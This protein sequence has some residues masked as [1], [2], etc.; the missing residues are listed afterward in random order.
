M[1]IIKKI[2]YKVKMISERPI[3]YSKQ[4]KDIRNYMEYKGD[5]CFICDEQFD[6]DDN[7]YVLFMENMPNKFVCSKCVDDLV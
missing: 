1:K 4:F 7:M 3:K 5:E 2:E 6:V